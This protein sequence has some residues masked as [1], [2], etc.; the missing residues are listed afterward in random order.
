MPV[1]LLPKDTFMIDP[2]LKINSHIRQAQHRGGA[3]MTG[4]K[5]GLLSQQ[6]LQ[7]TNNLELEEHPPTYRLE[8]D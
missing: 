5:L 3:Q 1:P 7:V 2:N 6:P 4:V 8:L